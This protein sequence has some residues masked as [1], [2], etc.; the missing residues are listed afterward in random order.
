M[1]HVE[2][3]LYELLPKLKN[4]KILEIDIQVEVDELVAALEEN[5]YSKYS[6]IFFRCS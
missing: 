4:L 1:H 2:R 5:K 3:N 6:K